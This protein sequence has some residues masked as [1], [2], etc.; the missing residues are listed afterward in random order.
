[1]IQI[2]SMADLDAIRDNFELW[3]EAYGFLSVCA[4]EITEYGDEEDLLDH[5][6]NMT[7]LTEQERD[8]LSGLGKPEEEIVTEV[9]SSDQVRIFHTLIYP[10][11]IILIEKISRS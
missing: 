7:V 5:D 1:M 6:F 11:E 3:R 10:T 9:R 2:N 4:Y 8:Y